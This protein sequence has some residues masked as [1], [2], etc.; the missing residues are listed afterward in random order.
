MAEQ[1]EDD[2]DPSSE[3]VNVPEKV[4][5][6]SDSANQPNAD[7]LRQSTRCRKP[8]DRYGY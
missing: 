2:D 5:T 6:T 3:P 4:M 1:E 7:T 8:V